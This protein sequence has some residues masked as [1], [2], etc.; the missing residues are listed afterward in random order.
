MNTWTGSESSEGSSRDISRYVPKDLTNSADFT[1]ELNAIDSNQTMTPMDKYRY[2]KQLMRAV[3]TAKQKEINHHL[4]SFEYYLMAR[5]DVEAKSITL[6]A[7]KAIMALEKDQLQMMKEIGLSHSDEIS[8]T[9]I[10][11]GNMLTSKLHEIEEST[12]LP[13]IKKTTLENVR[14]VWE[15][16][17]KRIMESVDTYIDEL[18]EKEQRRFK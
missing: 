8:T 7:Q 3:S 10:K 1:R 4:E 15:K 12:M 5:K 14:K 6:E 13:E 2:K 16:T 9:L 17:N 18:Y 11:A